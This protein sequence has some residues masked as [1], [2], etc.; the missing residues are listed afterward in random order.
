MVKLEILKTLE[1]SSNIDLRYC[2][3]IAAKSID[4]ESGC[5]TLRVVKADERYYMHIMHN[6]T[7][8][9]CFEIVLH[10]QPWENTSVFAFTPDDVH[11]YEFEVRGEKALRPDEKRI[12]NVDIKSLDLSAIKHGMKCTYNNN[13]ITYISE[14]E[15]DVNGNIVKVDAC[16]DYSYKLMKTKIK[17]VDGAKGIF[18][19]L[20][21]IAERG[22]FEKYPL[23]YQSFNQIIEMYS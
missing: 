19:F 1:K 4:D 5:M 14:N 17:A 13:T 22:K 8:K 10:W 20:E 7:V 12:S 16:C 11:I 3:I 9:Q 18:R 2:E 6:G 23:F 21:N 15:I